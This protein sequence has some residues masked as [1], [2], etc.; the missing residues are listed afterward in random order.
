[1]SGGGGGK[2]RVCRMREE[3]EEGKADGGRKGRDK[4]NGLQFST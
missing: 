1:M 4:E 3:K 2:V